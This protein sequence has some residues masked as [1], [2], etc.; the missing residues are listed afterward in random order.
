MSNKR[1]KTK[2]KGRLLI[3][4]GLVLLLCAASLAGY[5][6]YDAYSAGQAASSSAGYLETLLHGDV[7]TGENAA[8]DVSMVIP[9]AT[10]TPVP[11]ATSVPGDAQGTDSP[12]AAP[13][14]TPMPTLAPMVEIP[15][16]VLNPQ[17]QL[18]VATYEGERYIGML[19]IPAIDLKLPIIEWWSYPSLKKAPCRYAGSPYTSNMVIAAHN[20][21][22]H[23]GRLSELTGGEAV[24]FTDIDGNEFKYRVELVESLAARE[25]NYMINSGWDLSLFTCTPGGTY[26]VT[27]RCSKR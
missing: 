27:V 16:Y 5:N 18:P 20:Y 15:D 3:R 21:P 8:S 19:E 9:A 13:T 10:P 25:I 17:M 2:K 24:L 26:R 1:R 12:T 22:T 11:E 7:P 6:L 23:F 14:A 4:M